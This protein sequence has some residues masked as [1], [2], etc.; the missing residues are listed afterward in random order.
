MNR[1][2]ILTDV[3]A[4]IVKESDGQ[5]Q[6]SDIGVGP[7]SLRHLGLNSLATLRVLVAVEDEFGIE[8]DDD[9]D[10]AVMSDLQ[11]MCDHIADKLGVPA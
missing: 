8:W 3:K 4:L 5:I 10:E 1:A 2:Q 9:V 6:E 11:V 7:D